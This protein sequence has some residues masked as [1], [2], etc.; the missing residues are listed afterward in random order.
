MGE[1]LEKNLFYSAAEIV[2]D[3][4][5]TLL[6]RYGQV[7]YDAAARCADAARSAELRQMGET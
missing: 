6:K 4:A 2:C 5:I 7:C 3:G 1:D